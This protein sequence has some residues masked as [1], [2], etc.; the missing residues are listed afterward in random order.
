MTQCV[1]STASKSRQTRCDRKM[2]WSYKEIAVNSKQRVL[3]AV[4]HREPDRVP[5]FY[6]DEPEVEARLLKD[7]NLPDGEALMQYLQIDFRWV[8]PEYVGPS[9]KDE[10]AG[11]MRTIWGTELRFVPFSEAGGYWETVH[12]PLQD[13][14]DPADLDNYPWPSLEWFDFSTLKDQV[15][16]YRD[17]A[18]MPGGG[19]ASPGVLTT[20]Q[21]LCGEQKAWTDM[22]INPNFFQALLQR[23][24]DFQLR[25]IDKMMNASD[26]GLD[27]IRIGDD[28][29]TQRGLLIGPEPW[30]RFIKPAL[31]A[32]AQ[33]A[34]KHGAFYY[35]H[36]CGGIRQ[37]I[38]D[39]IESG[40][41]VLDP[42]QVKA[43][44]MVPAELKADFG[45]GICFSGGVDE[46][47]LLPL[48]TPEQIQQA[49]F[50]LLEE[51]APNG[52]FFLGPTHNF[53]VD[54]PTE[55]IV[56]MYQAGRQWAYS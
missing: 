1:G 36:S 37:L 44:G 16:R 12:H 35:H 46:Q 6:R 50:T 26:G 13:C 5:L 55:N 23:V 42:L 20:I 45:E 21:R 27:F 39:L 19:P 40:V 49:V 22:L 15:R 14:E 41:D 56:A 34:K 25:F 51:M 7:L 18:T 53:Q 8:S 54:I 10:K 17:Y 31:K 48:G 2:K 3:N 4:R 9:L 52:G 30:R 38:P 28:Y 43:C 33:I 24:L 11:H 32:F 29:G 47:E